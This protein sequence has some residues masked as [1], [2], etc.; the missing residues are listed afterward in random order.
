MFSLEIISFFFYYMSY[1][2]DWFWD[3][4]YLFYLIYSIT[5]KR[6]SSDSSFCSQPTQVACDLPATLRPMQFKKR[7]SLKKHFQVNIQ[8]RDLTFVLFISFIYAQ[9]FN[10]R[11]YCL[12][13]K[14]RWMHYKQLNDGSPPTMQITRCF[15]CRFVP[16]LDRN[17]RWR[18]LPAREMVLHGRQEVNKFGVVWRMK[19]CSGHLG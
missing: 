9:Y 11:F 3:V 5:D 18:F 16:Y 17:L 12:R 8:E 6:F 1:A 15:G 2:N 10:V 13:T 14:H 19:Q 7:A 4:Y